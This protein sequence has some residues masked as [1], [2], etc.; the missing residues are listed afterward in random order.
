MDIL[1]ITGYRP[2]GRKPLE[3]RRSSCELG[4]SPAADGSAMLEM[5]GTKV[6]ASVRGPREAVGGAGGPGA[7]PALTGGGTQATGVRVTVSFAAFAGAERRRGDHRDRRAGEVASQVEAALNGVV[8]TELFPRSRV[9]VLVH[10][11]QADGGVAAACFNACML[12]IVDAGVP[13]V[14]MSAACAVGLLDRT[15]LL[16]PTHNEVNSGSGTEVWVSCLSRSGKMVSCHFSGRAAPATLDDLVRRA[17]MGCA[18]LNNVLG[19]FVRDSVEAQM[20]AAGVV[21]S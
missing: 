7:A 8:Q 19:A 12:A 10:V 16:D 5:G 13:V 9:D 1:A 20:R 14:D 11:L 15:P 17:Q 18:E 3:L 4:V 6:V 2:D 21:P